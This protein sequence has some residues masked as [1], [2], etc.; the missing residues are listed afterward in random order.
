M[1]NYPR[2]WKTWIPAGALSLAI[3]FGSVSCVKR[4][5]PPAPAPPSK[6]KIEQVLL[7]TQESL[8]KLR[9]S[10]TASK[11]LLDD[12]Q[13]TLGLA[14]V[15]VTGGKMERAY[16][17]VLEA[18]RKIRAAR[19]A[20]AL[21]ASDDS[22]EVVRKQIRELKKEADKPQASLNITITRAE[23]ERAINEVAGRLKEARASQRAIVS[24]ISSTE[25]LLVRARAQLDEGLFDRAYNLAQKAGR[26]LDRIQAGLM[27][28]VGEVVKKLSRWKVKRRDNLWDISSDDR[29]YG[30]PILWPFIYR[31]NKDK[32]WNPD[33][34]YPGWK[35]SIQ[36]G[37]QR[38]KL[39]SIPIPTPGT[40]A[41]PIPPTP[42][43]R[44]TA[45]MF[46]EAVPTATPKPAVASP[47]EVPPSSTKVPPSPTKVPPS[48][49][50]VPP[51][52]TPEPSLTPVP[53]SPTPAPQALPPVLLP[54]VGKESMPPPESEY[55]DLDLD[56]LLDSTL[57]EENSSE[58]ETSSN[59]LP[60]LFESDETSDA[61]GDDSAG[62]LDSLLAEL[63][64]SMPD[65]EESQDDT[66][67]STDDGSESIDW[68]ELGLPEL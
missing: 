58:D 10:A 42:R 3:L 5:E 45:V 38:D 41:T 11:E 1:N 52:P 33:L 64:L 27:E 2:P 16:E 26:A 39:R 43:P 13:G 18:Q 21:A 68:E 40:K 36:R 28:K 22:P 12:A 59:D 14:K 24:Q 32:I 62:D 57:G 56:F 23:A 30:D 51:G 46:F 50:E 54:T 63:D 6:Q 35:L 19:A 44:P 53:A 66:N 9:E 48:P 47:T 37:S 4:A 34:I 67:T 8:E 55:D 7:E 31:A 25:D 20:S 60:L 61:E 15:E 29:V 49:T 65:D 17:L